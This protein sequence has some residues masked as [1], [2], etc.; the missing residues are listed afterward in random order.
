MTPGKSPSLSPSFI[1][2]SSSS[3]G[4]CEG[5]ETRMVRGLHSLAEAP[6][7]LENV[8]PP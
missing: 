8:A 2:E 3:L 5:L 6:R 1:T 7:W 4:D